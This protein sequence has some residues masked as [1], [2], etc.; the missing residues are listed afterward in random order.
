MS[1]ARRKRKASAPNPE[2]IGTTPEREA[3]NPTRSAGMARRIIPMIDILH[4]RG[5]LGPREYAILA[6]YRDQA[7]LADRSPMRSCCDVSPR[8]G[9]GPGVAIMSATLETARLERDMGSL[10]EIARKVAVDDWS[11]S[12]WCVEKFG[13]RERYDK[14]GKLVAIVPV[15]EK[16]HVQNARMELRMAARRIMGVD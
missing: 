6:Y 9:N 13:G 1:K 2:Y 12:R 4:E 11:L 5:D 7:S 3:I 15:N 10:W 14:N 16:R 8:G